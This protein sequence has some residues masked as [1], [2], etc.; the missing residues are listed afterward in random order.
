VCSRVEEDETVDSVGWG[1]LPDAGGRVT[2]D[3][4]VMLSPALLGGVC[5]LS[6]HRAAV[7]VAR[8]VMEASPHVLL[9]GEGADRF[10]D[11]QGFEAGSL[12]SPAARRRFEERSAGTGGSSRDAF[13]TQSHDT[14]CALALD[15]SGILA[16]ATSTSG[17][18]WKLPG[19]VGDTALV[20]QGLHVL[21]GV[22]AAAATGLGELAMGS[23][24][25]FLAVEE[26]RRG[27][28]PAEALGRAL[29][30]AAE[31]RDARRPAA[32]DA[33]A[34]QLAMIALTAD[35]S[36]ACAALEPGFEAVVL[37]RDV[38]AGRRLA[39]GEASGG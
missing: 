12:L 25:S 22:G 9:A 33:R 4:L 32:G 3:A 24:A 30:R 21:P 39:P 19:R 16:G 35:G 26:L 31:V 15:C 6:R 11:E 34:D 14:I 5:A 8:R 7:E 27:A 10:A 29:E 18:A 13:G 1:G 28:S 38:P 2:L 20:G 36:W 37:A 23:C 17:A